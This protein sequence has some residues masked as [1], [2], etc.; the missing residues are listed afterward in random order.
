MD[1][2]WYGHSERAPGF[3]R[4]AA[5]AIIAEDKSLRKP[6]IVGFYRGK[7]LV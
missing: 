6:I 3:L 5:Y 7:D 1:E 4:M 2:F